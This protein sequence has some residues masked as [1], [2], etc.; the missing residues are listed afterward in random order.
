MDKKIPDN[1]VAFSGE[2]TGG[3]HKLTY[4]GHVIL[5]YVWCHYQRYQKNK[6]KN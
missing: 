1:L 6:L 3:R 4:L 5:V 2:T